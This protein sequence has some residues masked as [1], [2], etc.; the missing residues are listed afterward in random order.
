MQQINDP[1]CFDGTSVS[2]TPLMK[3]ESFCTTGWT[4]MPLRLFRLQDVF[5]KAAASISAAQPT[6]PPSQSAPVTNT[7]TASS[8]SN[9]SSL[10]TE[11]ALS[12]ENASRL[13]ADPTASASVSSTPTIESLRYET[14]KWRANRQELGKRLV[15]QCQCRHALLNILEYC[16]HIRHID[17]N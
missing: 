9:L 6:A 8:Y 17:N 12:E 10:T 5:D 13:T 15:D 16:P 2:G 1:N 7:A 4:A 14:A 3:S 11:P